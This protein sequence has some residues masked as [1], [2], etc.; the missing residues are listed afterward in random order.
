MVNVSVMVWLL[1]GGVI[2]WLA[3]H[4][5]SFSMLA[6]IGSSAGVAVLLAVF[7]LIRRQP[8]R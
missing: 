7:S 5:S 4:Q 1:I 3:V 2:A 8:V 6:L